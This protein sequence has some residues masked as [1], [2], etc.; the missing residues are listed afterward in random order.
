MINQFSALNESSSSSKRDASN[1]GVG[2]GAAPAH[3]KLRAELAPVRLEPIDEEAQHLLYTEA[4]QQYGRMR[5]DMSKRL[6]QDILD[7]DAIRRYNP[8][9]HPICLLYTS[10]SPRD[11]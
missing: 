5:F 10:P 7:S 3:K 1:L 2:G 9:D 11:S 4:L 6:F 8:K